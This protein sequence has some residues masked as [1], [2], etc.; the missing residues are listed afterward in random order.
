MSNIDH[1]IPESRTS[2]NVTSQFMT[3]NV[4]DEDRTDQ[5]HQLD[6]DALLVFLALTVVITTAFFVA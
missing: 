2:G 6:A 1:L 3:R 4:D 5:A